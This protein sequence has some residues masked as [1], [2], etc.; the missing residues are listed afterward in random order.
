MSILVTGGA[1]SGKSGFAERLT[2]SLAEQAVYVATAQ[3]FDDEMKVRI[4]LHRRQRGESGGQ[5]QTLEEPHELPALL[6]RLSGGRAVLVDC[7][8]LWL[9]NVLLAVESEPD[10]QERVE[11]EIARLEDSV[12]SFQ[13]TLVLVTNEVGDGIVPEYALGR[14]YRDLAGRMNARV[15]ARCQ[16]VFLVTAGIPI[17]LKSREYKL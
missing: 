11:Q 3:S 2:L 6:D 10:R 1:R 13:G 5:W 7:L 17:E 12:S 4:A 8:T 9:S 15:A 16:Q 14:L